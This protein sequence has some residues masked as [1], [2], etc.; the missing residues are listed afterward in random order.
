MPKRPWVLLLAG[1]VVLVVSFL[2]VNLL[3]P[4]KHTGSF[5]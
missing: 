3:F 1:F 5:D 4:G 2:S